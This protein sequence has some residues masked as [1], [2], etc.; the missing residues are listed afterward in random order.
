MPLALSFV[1]L[2][3]TLLIRDSLLVFG[4]QCVGELH[5]KKRFNL[6]KFAPERER[7]KSE[8]KSEEK[9]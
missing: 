8:G 3:A 4:V 9:K 6:I 1:F 5:K 2:L 7:E